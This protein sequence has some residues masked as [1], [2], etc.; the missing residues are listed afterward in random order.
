MRKYILILGFLVYAISNFA[1]ETQVAYF[2]YSPD[3]GQDGLHFKG[4]M[5]YQANTYGGP[6]F[7]VAIEYVEITGITHNGEEYDSRH[8]EFP[9]PSD[10][11]GSIYFSG[12]FTLMVTL[13]FMSHLKMPG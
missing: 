12:I 13:G 6:H 4:K 9:N 11:K 8:L 1:Q 5:L 7:R 2:E 10:V 3:Y